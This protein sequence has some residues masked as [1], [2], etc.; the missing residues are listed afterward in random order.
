MTNSTLISCP[1]PPCPPE[2]FLDIPATIRVSVSLLVFTS[3]LPTH[4]ESKKKD[5]KNQSGKVREVEKEKERKSC[6]FLVIEL[7]PV[8]AGG[9][10]S[11]ELAGLQASECPRFTQ[12][13]RAPSLKVGL[14][15]DQVVRATSVG[16][17]ELQRGESVCNSA[18]GE[19]YGLSSG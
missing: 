4:R 6:C 15:G 14:D 19:T 13:N 8:Q 5:R 10:W 17:E 11:K 7:P 3:I 12:L 1:A 2:P 9:T 16:H 18:S